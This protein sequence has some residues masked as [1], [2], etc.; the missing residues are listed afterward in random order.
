MSS[1]PRTVWTWLRNGAEAFPAMLVAIDAARTSVCLETYIYSAGPLG[2]RFRDTLL[3]AQQ[4]G[5]RVRLRLDAVGSRSLPVSYWNGLRIAAGEVRIFN[6][7]ALKRFEIRDH[8]KLL[9]CDNMIAFV[10]GFNIASEYEGDGVTCG[11]LDLGLKV[12][13]I[14]AAQ[15]AA[16]FDEMFALAEFRHKRFIRLRRAALK[17]TVTTPDEHFLLAAVRDAAAI[18]SGG[19]CKRIWRTG[20]TCK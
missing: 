20:V 8:R 7:L 11:W 18:R 3:R 10:G 4:R 19:R 12:E 15:L 5:V 6:P 1:P 14:L 13:G 9:A 2:D 16:S 17:R